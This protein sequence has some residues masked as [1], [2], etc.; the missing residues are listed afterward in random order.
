MSLSLK[1]KDVVH[2][3]FRDLKKSSNFYRKIEEGSL[4]AESIASLLV[5]TKYLISKTPFF[6]AS[7]KNLATDQKVVE[8]FAHTEEEEQGHDK[9]AEDDLEKL[10]VLFK[11]ERIHISD[12]IKDIE[13]YIQS[14]INDDPIYLIPYIFWAE[15]TAV[16][17]APQFAADIK[18]RCNIGPEVLSVFLNHAELDQEHTEHDNEILEYLRKKSEGYEQKA[19]EIARKQSSLYTDF[20]NDISEIR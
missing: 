1:L 6:A 16:H 14:L 15:Y 19:L 11:V 8:Y 5:S 9:W 12:K 18:A 3:F 2:T 13:K 4:G 10:K 20:L 17:A 7:A